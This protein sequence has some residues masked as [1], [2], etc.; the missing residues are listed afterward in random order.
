M[1]VEYCRRRHLQVADANEIAQDVLLQVSRSIGRFD[2]APERGKFRSWLIV[3]VRSKLKQ[4]VRTNRKFQRSTHCE[5][6]V[7]H[8]EHEVDSEWTD[9][10]QAQLVA[11]AMQQV[12]SQMSP[13]HFT[14]FRA[15]WVDGRSAEDV[16]KEIA[17]PVS[18]VYVAKC[19]GLRLLR[20]AIQELSDESP[21]LDGADERDSDA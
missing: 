20:S 12:E 17:K 19:R 2:Y 6:L 1:I 9:V 10:W 8:L 11:T 15:A 14:A 18:W 16:S 5:T 7:E 13:L 4:F 21:L 3:I